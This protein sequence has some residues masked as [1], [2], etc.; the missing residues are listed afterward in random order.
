MPPAAWQDAVS[1]SP[2]MLLATPDSAR[3]HLLP[4]EPNTSRELIS[5]WL[6]PYR[7]LVL[8][9]AQSAATTS[10]SVVSWLLYSILLTCFW[11][12]CAH[13]SH[14]QDVSEM[15]RKHS[16]WAEDVNVPESFW[17][18]NITFHSPFLSWQCTHNITQRSLWLFPL[19]NH[20]KQKQYWNLSSK[21]S[22]LYKPDKNK[23]QK[24]PQMKRIS[25]K[26]LLKLK[27]KK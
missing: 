9:Q 11:H 19:T 22:I 13:S 16:F 4:Q 21:Q 6:L 23:T 14:S 5:F 7:T 25:E 2:K 27:K 12:L 18:G 3:E 17:K 10:V 20:T 1:Y 24:H 15:S 26:H 8:H